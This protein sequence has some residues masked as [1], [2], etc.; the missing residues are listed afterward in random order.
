MLE[1]I[2]GCDIMKRI[3]VRKEKSKFQKMID[4]LD[5]GKILIISLFKRSR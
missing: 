2:I 4:I 1:T 3:Y 5:M